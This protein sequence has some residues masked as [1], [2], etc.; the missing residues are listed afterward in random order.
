MAMAN[1]TAPSDSP[2][3]PGATLRPH[4][5]AAAMASM[6][7]AQIDTIPKID[8]RLAS[9]SDKKN[10]GAARLPL[11]TF[12]NLTTA[13]AATPCQLAAARKWWRQPLQSAAGIAE[14]ATGEPPCGVTLNTQPAF[15]T[16]TPLKEVLALIAAAVEGALTDAY[17]STADD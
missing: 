15:D 7:P 9:A 10:R 11:F 8:P 14:Q 6:A 16:A 3:N 17:S 1:P 12:R 5:L 4:A 2:V 13:V